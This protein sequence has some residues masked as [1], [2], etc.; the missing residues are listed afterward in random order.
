MLILELFFFGFNGGIGEGIKGWYR[1]G[2]N[3]G[4]ILDFFLGCNSSP[5]VLLSCLSDTCLAACFDAANSKAL[6]VGYLPLLTLE[7][8]N[9]H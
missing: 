9:N 8:N 1:Q 4:T 3:I 2:W 7:E 6:V 5:Q